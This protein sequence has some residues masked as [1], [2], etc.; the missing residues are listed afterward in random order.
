[1]DFFLVH[2]KSR[3]NSNVIKIP[4][5]KKKKSQLKALRTLQG[6]DGICLSLSGWRWQKGEVRVA[7][8]D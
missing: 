3:E 7:S 5:T 8:R 4:E 2:L 6:E 1:M